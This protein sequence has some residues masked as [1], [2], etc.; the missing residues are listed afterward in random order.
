VLRLRDG[1][2][3]LFEMCSVSNLFLNLTV[4][5]IVDLEW[6]YIRP[7][8]LFGSAPWWLLQD[9]PVNNAWNCKGDQPPKIA[10]RYF[11][12]LEIFI[13]V[14]KEEEAKLVGHK[15]RELS[16]LIKWLQASGAIWLHILL[17][18][19]FNDYCSFPFI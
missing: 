8:Q 10:A 14:L 6:S 12:Y 15:D 18:S 13:H 9:R 3:T 7:A 11:K 4:I 2:K 5:G 1:E 16:S 17:L 19:G